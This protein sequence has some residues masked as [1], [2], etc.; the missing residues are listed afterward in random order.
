MDS[1]CVGGRGAATLHRRSSISC[2]FSQEQTLKVNAC[3]A[4][5]EAEGL[6]F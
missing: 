3:N 2:G 4:W 5:I 6:G 1:S